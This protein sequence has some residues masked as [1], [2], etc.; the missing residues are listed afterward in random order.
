MPIDKSRKTV[1]ITVDDGS[2]QRR[3]ELPPTYYGEVALCFRAGR[4]LHV[5]KTELELVC[6]DR[7]TRSAANVTPPAHG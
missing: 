4:L 1:I 7:K 6:D 2:Q 5:K 3:I